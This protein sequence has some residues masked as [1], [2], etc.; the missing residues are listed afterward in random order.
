[1]FGV[2]DKS[3]WKNKTLTIYG[4]DKINV[5]KITLKEIITRLK[6]EEA[7]WLSG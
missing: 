7:A 3:G 5:W 4:Y 6:K 2:E 1:M